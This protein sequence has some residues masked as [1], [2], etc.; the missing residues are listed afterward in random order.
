MGAILEPQPVLIPHNP[1]FNSYRKTRSEAIVGVFLLSIILGHLRV[2]NCV[3][4]AVYRTWYWKNNMF[5]IK[6]H[7]QSLI[8]LRLLVSK[9]ISGF[10]IYIFTRTKWTLATPVPSVGIPPIPHFRTNRSTGS[11]TVRRRL[12]PVDTSIVRQ[13]CLPRR[14]LSKRCSLYS[15]GFISMHG[16]IFP[17]RLFK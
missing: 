1:D 12:C 10:S 11:P 16:T 9:E 5:E 6:S 7:L 17:L 2:H 13:P 8:L 3:L 14:R 15:R 4:C